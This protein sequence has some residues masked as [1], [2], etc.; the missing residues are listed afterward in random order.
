[1]ILTDLQAFEGVHCETTTTGTLLRQLGIQMSEPMLFGLGEGLGFLFWKMKFMD[2]PFIG[3]RVKPLALT[4]NLAQNLGLQLEVLETTSQAKAWRQVQAKIDSGTAV[5]LQL[6]SFHLEYFQVKF[7]FAGHFATIYG[8]Q[9]DTAFMV[10]TSPNGGQVQTSLQSLAA[11]RS[12]KGAMAAKNLMYTL[13]GSLDGVDLRAAT[14]RAV[15]NNARQYLNPPIKNIGYKG[16]LKTSVEIAKWFNNSV[17]V[18]HEFTTTAMLM[19][20]AGTGGSLFRNLYR[21]FLA[22]AFE[23]TQLAPLNVA[24]QHFV[25]IA[26]LWREVAG[27]FEKAGREQDIS[28]IKAASEILVDLSKREF[29]A[30][31]LLQDLG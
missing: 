31:S 5:G 6:D 30:M 20:E 15:E 21:D 29:E 7:H 14:I 22:E 11:A 25:E 13:A 1:M 2:F 12:E 4:K 10:D 18:E 16:I 27:L 24:H 28:H 9:N 19:E 26:E 17:D 23:L 3:G 8:C